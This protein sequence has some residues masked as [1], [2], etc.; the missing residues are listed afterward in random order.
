[1][2]LHKTLKLS[3]VELKAD[4]EAGKFSGYASVFGGVDSYGDTILPGAFKETLAAGVPK[5]FFNHEWGMPIGKYTVLKEDDRG[6]YVEGEFT[7]G[8]ALATDVHAAMRHGTLDGLSIGGYLSS[9]DYEVKDGNRIIHKWSR[10]MEISPV[11]FP[12]DNSARI[13][14]VKSEELTAAIEQL[15]TIRDFERLLRDAGG[16]SKGAAA[17]LAARVKSMFARRDAGLNDDEAKLAILM[18][19]RQISQ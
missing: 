2:L 6:L 9:K 13:E 12:A 17:A 11:V 7:P 15:E 5:M 3:E 1:M 19:I 10:L 8:L 16:F 4:S 18:K 14:S